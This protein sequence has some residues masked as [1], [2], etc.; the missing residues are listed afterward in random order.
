MSDVGQY[1]S[2][3]VVRQN[4]LFSDACFFDLGK[5]LRDLLIV[6]AIDTELV[7]L[8]GNGCLAAFLTQYDI[9]G[10]SR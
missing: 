3:F 8:V 7:E 9:A 6:D 2:K 5:K 1:R 10:T 4:S